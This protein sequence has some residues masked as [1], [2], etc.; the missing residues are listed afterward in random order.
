MNG[1]L[2]H[3]TLLREYSSKFIGLR[4]ATIS[5]LRS[6]LA[7]RICDPSL[8]GLWRRTAIANDLQPSGCDSKYGRSLASLTLFSRTFHL[9][10]NAHISSYTN[11][12]LRFITDNGVTAMHLRTQAFC[13]K[14]GGGV[15][16]L[17]SV[18]S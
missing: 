12:Q 8:I 14:S 6:L 4:E 2:F 16:D 18:P 13:A 9:P 17:R 10:L 7:L 5:T 1:I 3:F 11:L 15:G